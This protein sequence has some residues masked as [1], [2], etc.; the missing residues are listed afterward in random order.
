MDITSIDKN[1][2]IKSTVTREGLTFINVLN[3]E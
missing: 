3:R 2:E 1:F